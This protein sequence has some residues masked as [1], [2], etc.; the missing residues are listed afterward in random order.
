[1]ASAALTETNDHMNK[2]INKQAGCIKS[3][4]AALQAISYSNLHNLN[5][6]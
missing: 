4:N 2:Q 1:M 5:K 6:R 3:T